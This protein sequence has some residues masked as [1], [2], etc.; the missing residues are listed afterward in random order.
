MKRT[1][2]FALIVW[3]MASIAPPAKATTVHQL[4]IDPTVSVV[5]YPAWIEVL[6][7]T[8]IDP[9]FGLTIELR[10]YHPANSLPI[11]GELKVI[12]GRDYPKAIEFETVDLQPTLLPDGRPFGVSISSL[13]LDDGVFTNSPWPNLPPDAFCACIHS[14]DP[15]APNVEGTFDGRLLTL[16]YQAQAGT[17]TAYSPWYRWVGEQPPPGTDFSEDISYYIEATAVPL[18]S[19]L[20][21]LLGSLIII[22]GCRRRDCTTMKAAA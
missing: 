16:Q 17:A 5:N 2:W 6:P 21:M 8:E 1:A 12:L 3:M 19:P 9:T 10:R 7:E 20:L 13:T 15:F 18:P 4:R 22:P 14:A 11:I